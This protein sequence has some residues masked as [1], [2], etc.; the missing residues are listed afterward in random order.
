MRKFVKFVSVATVVVAATLLV[1]CA[2][3][4]SSTTT[5]PKEPANNRSGATISQTYVE[6]EDGRT[7]LCLTS[8]EGYSGGIS[9]DWD[10]ATR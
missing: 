4:G 6:L 2:D 3:G 5:A 7:V 10:N 8:K 1:G 9:C